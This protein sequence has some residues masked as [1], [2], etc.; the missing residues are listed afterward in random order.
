LP[1]KIKEKKSLHENPSKGGNIHQKKVQRILL[2]C[3]KGII[4]M[5]RNDSVKES[6]R[7]NMKAPPTSA[8]GPGGWGKGTDVGET[9]YAK[10]RG[11]GRNLRFSTGEIALRKKGK[12]FFF[13][14]ELLAK[15]QYGNGENH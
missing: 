2:V 9:G 4:R 13:R 7:G 6:K 8:A 11:G 1:K 10:P 15:R 3:E 5:E 12:K 14:E